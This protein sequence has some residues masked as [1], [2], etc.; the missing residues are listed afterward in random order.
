MGNREMTK[1][2]KK[3]I[4]FEQKIG[5]LTADLQRTRADFENYRKRVDVE[6]LAARASGKVEATIKLLPII[7]NINRAISHMPADLHSNTWAIGVVGLAKNLE[8]M[9]NELNLTKIE[10]K[11]GMAFNPELHHAVLL[12]ENAEGDSLDGEEIVVE[13]LQ[14]GYMLNGN[15]IRHAMVKVA[16]Q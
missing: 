13:E 16:R 4:E 8:K 12:D 7:D 1:K 14:P 11:P 3:D 6:K 2:S 10:A 9:M 5:E 15:P